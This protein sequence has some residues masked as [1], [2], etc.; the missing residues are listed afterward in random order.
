M[1]DPNVHFGTITVIIL[2]Y[3]EEKNIAQALDSVVGWADDIFIL[4]SFSS[5]K[6]LD[7]ASKYKCNIA[8]NNF[9]NYADQRNYALDQIPIET[10]WVFFLDADEWLP[11]KLKEEISELIK[12]NREENGY[13]VKWRLMWMG[14]WIKRGYYPTWILRLF[15][16]GKAYCEERAVNEHLI[17][18]GKI[19][20]LQNDFIHEDQKAL[21]EWINK[22]NKY[23]TREALELYKNYKNLHQKEIGDRLFGTQAERKRWIRHKIWNKLPPLI[24]PILYFIYRYFLAGGFLDGKNAFIYHFLQAL[25]FP[26]LIDIK[27]LEIKRKAKTINLNKKNS[28]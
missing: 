7:I 8:Q 28:S 23:A 25:W 26:M 13:Y 6:T 14:G 21:S 3:N 18:D 12:S 27:F 4:D 9:K 17:V 20:Y 16:Y 2:T 24:R 22:H 1:S 11:D 19:G 15:R 10:S 5:D